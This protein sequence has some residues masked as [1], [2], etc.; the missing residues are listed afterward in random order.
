MLDIERTARELHVQR[1]TLD[2]LC[3]NTQRWHSLDNHYVDNRHQPVI[4]TPTKQT[5]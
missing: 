5:D 3:A 1:A 2:T 4:N